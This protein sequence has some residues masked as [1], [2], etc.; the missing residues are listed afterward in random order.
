[1]KILF[2]LPVVGQPRFNK[3]IEAMLEEGAECEALTFDRDYFAGRPVPC[4]SESL[5]FVRPGDYSRRLCQYLKALRRVRQKASAADVVYAFGIDMGGLAALAT[6][7]LGVT[8]AVEVGDIR[9]I[10]VSR[11]WK[12]VLVRALERQIMR[13]VHIVVVT[14][15]EFRDKYFVRRLGL[16]CA[17]FVV[18]ENKLHFVE[19]LR[20]DN[21]VDDG[22]QETLRIGYFGLLRCKKSL[23]ALRELVQMGDG[24]I[25][26]YLRGYPYNNV[27][28]E[29]NELVSMSNVEYGGEYQSPSDL[30]KI[31]GSVDLVWGCYPHQ[32]SSEGNWSWARTNRFYESCYFQ[33][34]IVV[35]ENSGDAYDV[36]RLGIGIEVDLADP[37]AAAWKV[38]DVVPGQLAEL[39]N[40]VK[41]VPRE[42][43]LYSTEHQY[44]FRR[45][46]LCRSRKCLFN[47]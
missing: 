37:V 23:R 28:Q 16:D 36:K 32:G 22:A 14:S 9:P 39:Q 38:L 8:L 33:R 5:G 42:E 11:E 2:L 47:I 34:P 17:K 31:Y 13:F 20:L 15:N 12:G 1:M 43:F 7:G 26:V 21:N 18:V 35:Q 44:L 40:A 25:S 3:R 10:Q 41:Q 24:K 4:V 30:A 6:T 27:S 45:L 46:G 19:S 29:F